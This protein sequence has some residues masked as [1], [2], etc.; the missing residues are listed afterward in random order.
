MIRKLILFAVLVLVGCQ[1][2]GNQP[3]PAPFPPPRDAIVHGRLLVGDSELAT[4]SSE[5][6]SA[7][8]VRIVDLALPQDADTYQATIAAAERLQDSGE[9]DWVEFDYIFGTADVPNDTFYDRQWHLPKIEAANAWDTTAGDSDVII[10]IVDTGI[11]PGHPDLADKLLPGHDFA[12]S[13]SDARDDNG[14]GTHVAGIA[15]AITD[16]GAGVAGI[17]RRCR[18]LPVKALSAGGSGS[19]SAIANGIVWAAN[20][21]AKVIN[22][23]LGGPYSSNT[24]REAV[25]YAHERGAL[26]VAAAGN[27]NTSQC[28]YP[29]CYDNAVAVAATDANDQ[30]ASFSNYG[31][32]VSISAPGV[33][34]LSTWL[35]GDYREASGTS[36][37]SPVVAGVAGLVASQFPNEGPREWRMRIETAA[38]GVGSNLGSGRVNAAR[39]VIGASDGPQPTATQIQPTPESGAAGRMIQL[40]N[41]YR[42]DNGLSVL[43]ADDSLLAA[44]QRHSQDMAANSFCGHSGSNGSLPWDRAQE[45]GYPSSS[46]GEIVACGQSSAQA[47]VDAWKRSS[48]HNQIM[49]GRNWTDIGCGYAEGGRYRRLYTCVFGRDTSSPRPTPRPTARPTLTVTPRPTVMPTEPVDDS[50]W[51]KCEGDPIRCVERVP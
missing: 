23:S 28:G 2:A 42:A 4:N 33:S 18:I 37:A 50:F 29:A 10:A 34:I 1:T 35:G 14:H 39:A 32:W 25:D 6:L 19:N 43:P 38:E 27:S 49:V 44:G 45:A 47:A 24:L 7:I 11:D 22:L 21:G 36:M 31:Q 30:R 41:Q 51:M 46:V 26:V 3:L 20:A 9:Y 5:P 17:C 8:G 12:N 13:D 16:N 40:I 48:G 15:A